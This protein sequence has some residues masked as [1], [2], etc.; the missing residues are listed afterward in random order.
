[1]SAPTLYHT[2]KYQG[3]TAFQRMTEKERGLYHTKKY[4]GATAKWVQPLT[5]I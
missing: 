5:D 2:K 1:M 4:Q 3:A